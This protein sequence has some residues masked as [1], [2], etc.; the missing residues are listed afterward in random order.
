MTP[1]IRSRIEYLTS[2]IV[3]FCFI[4]IQIWWKM[5]PNNGF[6]QDLMM[7]RWVAYFSRPTCCKHVVDYL[8]TFATRKSFCLT[9]WW[10]S[11]NLLGWLVARWHAGTLHT[12][13]LRRRCLWCRAGTHR[14]RQR[15]ER[16]PARRCAVA[17]RSQ[18]ACRR[19]ASA[20][21]A[22]ERK[23]E[24]DSRETLETEATVGREATERRRRCCLSA[25]RTATFLRAPVAIGKQ[26]F[27]AA[28]HR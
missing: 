18:S 3:L 7:L 28:C 14:G 12:C 9:D 22:L 2:H 25:S 19:P 1:Q 11:R 4:Y 16:R 5:S 13:R 24:A 8:T 27:S 21:W 23:T 15:Q 10:R 6:Q 20:D 26:H 17:A